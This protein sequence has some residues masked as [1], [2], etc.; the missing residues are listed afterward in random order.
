MKQKSGIY[1]PSK[2]DI[3]FAKKLRIII[4]GFNRRLGKEM[5]KEL[6]ANCFDCKTRI[7]IAILNEWI[8]ILI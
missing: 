5:C 6:H 4:N 7:A 3:E 2:A 8:D 1:K